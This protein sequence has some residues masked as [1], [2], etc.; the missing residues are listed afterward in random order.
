MDSYFASN[1]IQKTTGIRGFSHYISWITVGHR[2][3]DAGRGR[4]MGA[5]ISHLLN[6]FKSCRIDK[7]RI[8][9]EE[10]QENFRVEDVFSPGQVIKN[11][12]CHQ[13]SLRSGLSIER[14]LEKVQI[15]NL[16]SYTPN[17]TRQALLLVNSPRAELRE[18]RLKQEDFL[19][20]IRRWIQGSGDRIE[21]LDF[22]YRCYYWDNWT[23]ADLSEFN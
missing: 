8:E 1:L 7:V 22:C 14:I 21:F 5:V 23:E 3:D 12:E 18:T 20:F 16:V 4:E 13:E 19:E 11:F 15:E 10:M 6:V 9:F 2:K 17:L